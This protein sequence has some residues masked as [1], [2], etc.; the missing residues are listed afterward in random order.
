M[1]DSETPTSARLN[2][3]ESSQPR[4]VLDANVVASALVNPAGVPGQII[5]R[6]FTDAAADAAFESIVSLAT[7][8]ELR[9]VV[10]YPRLRSHI[11]LD[12]DALA[13]VIEYFAIVSTVVEDEPLPKVPIVEADPDDD[14]YLVVA[15]AGRAAYVVSGDRHLLNMRAYGEIAIVSPR[16]FA[17]LLHG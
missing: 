17:Q 11:H 10:A 4:A 12:D 14:V 15:A 3:E 16:Q 9:R 2:D 1:T 6:L 13:H 8:A 7:L 5:T